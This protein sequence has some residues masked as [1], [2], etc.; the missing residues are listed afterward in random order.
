MAT[1]AINFKFTGLTTPISSYDQNKTN[2][3]TLIKQYTGALSTDKFAGP[4]KIGITRPMEQSVAIP[5]IYPHVITFSDT[6]DW[7]FLA[8]NSAAA[9]TRRIILYEYNKSD[10]T[11]NW[12]GFLTLTYPAV[13]NHTIRGFRVSR[14]L[15]TTGTISASGTSVTGTSTLWQSDRLSVGCRIGFGSTNPNL[16]STWYEISSIVSDTSITLTTSAGTITSGT[17]YVIEDIILITSTTNATVTNGGLFIAKGIRPELFTPAGTTIPAATTVDNIRA[18]YWLA[19]AAVVTNTVA[20]GSALGNKNSWTDQSVYVLN[21]TGAAIYVYNFRASLTLTA[22]KDTTTNTIKTGNQVVTGTLSQAN[23]GRIYTLNHGPGSGVESLY[24]VTTT[25]VYRS[26]ISSITNGSVSWQSD[27]MVEIPPGGVATYLATSALTSCEI[28]SG[29]DRLVITT[30]GA[31]GVRSYITQYNTSSNPFDHIFLVDDKQQDQSTSDSGS[32]PH[33]AILASPFSVWSEN[34]I[35]YLARVGT[36]AAINQIYTLPIG[37]HQTYA[38]NNQE[39]LITPKFD[40]SDSSKLYNIYINRVNKVGT[41]TFSLPTEPFKLY[42]RTSGIS[43]NSG[44]WTLLSDDGDLSGISG[45]EIQFAISFKIIGTTCLPA[46]ILGLSLVYEDNSTD[47]HY[48]PSVNK[49]SIITNTFAYRQSILWSSYIPNM[50]I[51]MY[52]AVTGSLILDDN[53]LSSA[54]GV[55]EYSSNDGSSWNTWDISQDVV[56]NYIRYTA[57]S[58]PNSTKIKVLLTQA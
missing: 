38:I 28:S 30:S 19:D 7:V 23:N 31:A 53:I 21:V 40:I 55:W 25:R 57:T 5:G 43:D 32:V 52:N 10:S 16:I 8:D 51:R 41:D 45:S 56:G 50:R 35:L 11:F 39:L 36:T 27:T 4:S 12:K 58:L 6:I 13:T 14:E 3:G 47:G 24:Y 34:G 33:P 46:R 29:I 20:A 44:S 18:V 42:Y 2:L 49:S 22:G 26:A 54:Y 9:V 17:P 15:Y 37:A 1:K 48:Q